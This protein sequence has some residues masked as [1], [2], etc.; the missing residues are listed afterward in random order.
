ML[1]TIV[2]LGM[3][4]AAPAQVATAEISVVEVPKSR[5]KETYYERRNIASPAVLVGWQFGE[6]KGAVDGPLVTVAGIRDT[7]K[8][9]CVTIEHVGGG[10][11]GAAVIP[12]PHRGGTIRLKLPSTLFTTRKNIKSAD[13]ALIAEATGNGQCS[14][15]VSM[16]SASWQSPMDRT[17]S[18]LF[19]N[20]GLGEVARV[21]IP[22]A[23]AAEDCLPLDQFDPD[24]NIVRQRFNTV[25]RVAMPK[26]CV[27]D[28]RYEIIVESGV[29]RAPPVS[30]TI[31]RECL[32]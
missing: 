24:P 29:G 32:K 13:L 18:S 14:G 4:V 20:L 26:V 1:T 7:D 11:V 6:I 5:F 3:I 16:L 21:S 15:K 17:H 27:S 19:L 22:G 25:C 28:Q 31:R 10:Y 12:N 9:I 30:G 2:A 23:P 8:T